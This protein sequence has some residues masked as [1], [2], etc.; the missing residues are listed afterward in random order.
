MFS[1]SKLLRLKKDLFLHIYV[2]MCMS[3]CMTHVCSYMWRPGNCE[4][5]DIGAEK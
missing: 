1:I 2:C 4:T 5:Q 3:M